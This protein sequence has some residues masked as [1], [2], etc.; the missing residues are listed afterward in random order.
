MIAAQDLDLALGLVRPGQKILDGHFGGSDGAGPADVGI[1]AR[2]I[3]QHA[4][5]QRRSIVGS[6]YGKSGRAQRDGRDAGQYPAAVA[7]KSLSMVEASLC[8]VRA[9]CPGTGWLPSARIRR[10][11]RSRYG[12]SRS[13][14]RLSSTSKP[15]P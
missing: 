2:H 14:S 13:I 6:G 5:P 1:Q 4:D 9:L 10:A 15:P 11:G 8:R 12:M 7:G 3:G